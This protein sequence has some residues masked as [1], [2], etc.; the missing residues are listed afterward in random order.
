M[1]FIDFTQ[2][3]LQRKSLVVA[4]VQSAILKIFHGEPWENLDLAR[5]P[6]FEKVWDPLIQHTICEKQLVHDKQYKH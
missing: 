5:E 3:S 1:C 2:R 6:Q 4:I